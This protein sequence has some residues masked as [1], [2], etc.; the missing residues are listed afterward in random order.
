[1]KYYFTLLALYY[2]SGTAQASGVLPIDVPPRPIAD[3]L[4]H[5]TPAGVENNSTLTRNTAGSLE[6]RDYVLP[7]RDLTTFYTKGKHNTIKKFEWGAF[8]YQL[9]M[10]K[11]YVPPKYRVHKHKPGKH[12]LGDV[13]M[14]LLEANVKSRVGYEIKTMSPNHVVD[15]QLADF[16]YADSERPGVGTFNRAE[17]EYWFD[18]GRVQVPV[19]Y[20]KP[21]NAH[22]KRM[23]G[24]ANTLD[25]DGLYKAMDELSRSSEK[26]IDE[27]HKVHKR[28]VDFDSEE[29]LEA[30]ARLM[31]ERWGEPNGKKQDFWE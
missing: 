15:Y 22:E 23:T 18:Q 13:D 14:D 20:K 7:M 27:S 24:A 30:R 19:K 31:E 26:H 8:K 9:S 28:A 2:F 11:A 21:A 25:V 3:S 17:F 6:A 4:H 29:D 10:G 12:Y 16:Y 1:M 5:D